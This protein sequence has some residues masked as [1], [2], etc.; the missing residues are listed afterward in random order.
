MKKSITIVA[1]VFAIMTAGNL[2]A[3]DSMKSTTSTSSKS[4]TKTT[5]VAPVV[6]SDLP[7]DR[8]L[9]LRVGPRISTLSGD[10]RIGATGTTF[11]IWDD[12]GLDE[13]SAGIQLDADYQP[14]N[15]FHAMFGFTWDKYDHS[16]TTTKDIGKSAGDTERLLSGASVNADFD[17]YTF[18]GKLGYDV[19]KT[20]T[21]RLQ[22]YIG[23]KGGL[24]DGSATITGSTVSSTGVVT[25]NR[26]STFNTSNNDLVY[27]TFIGGLDSRLN[28]S[29]NWYVGLDVAGFGW[30]RV[31]YI[32]G[33]AYTGYDFTKNL[34]VRV[35]YSADW[36]TYE[37]KNKTTNTEP[38][39]GAGYLQFV[40][41]F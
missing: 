36:A 16:G 26:T 10:T 13:P 34:G 28:V 3:D 27:G 12:A 33:D 20:K 5:K 22:P 15:R 40:W 29:R 14:F 4:T 39:L 18:E 38:L 32:T 11:D 35:G 17:I 7:A 31:G 19:I 30:E 41:G 1:S 24:V 6:K 2:L 21:F 8:S 37:N 23:G 25:A 9:E